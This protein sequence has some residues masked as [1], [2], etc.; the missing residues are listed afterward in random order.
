LKYFRLQSENVGFVCELAA[1][2]IKA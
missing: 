2:A 1:C